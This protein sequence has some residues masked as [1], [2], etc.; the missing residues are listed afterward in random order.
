MRGEIERDADGCFFE[1][2]SNGLNSL[3]VGV[4]ARE[5]LMISQV[6]GR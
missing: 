6:K 1:I 2:K 4:R 5:V 3:K